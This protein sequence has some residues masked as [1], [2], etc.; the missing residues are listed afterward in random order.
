[1]KAVSCLALLAIACAVVDAQPFQ[2]GQGLLPGGN[3]RTVDFAGPY[4]LSLLSTQ[5]NEIQ[6]GMAAKGNYTDKDIIDFL[7]NV[8]CLEGQFDTYGAF[9][10]GFVGNLSGGGPAPMNARKANLSEHILPFIQEIALSEQGHALFTRHAG[11]DVPCP[12]IDYLAGFNELFAA[13]YELPAGVTVADEFG[14]AFDPWIN[15]QTFVL[16]VVT[17]EELGATGNKGLIGLITNPVIANGV[18]GLATS[19]TAFAAIERRIL[20]DLRNETVVPFNETV[21]QVFARMSAY[22]DRMDG[23]QIDDQGLTNTDPKYI[24][25]PDQYVNMIPTDVR[26]LTFSRTPQMNLNILTVGSPTGKGGFFPEGLNGAIK[27]PAGYNVSLNGTS[28]LPAQPRVATQ[29]SVAQVGTIPPPI[30]AMAPRKVEGIYSLTQVLSGLKDNGTFITRGFY[31]LPN[32]GKP[33]RNNR[34]GITAVAYPL[35]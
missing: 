27:T 3:I 16:S 13:V 18:A 15:D 8:E 23:V 28:D 25:V 12:A 1:M 9:G 33:N 6:A 34:L 35:A 20:W 4:N 21:Q 7:V 32:I 22:R 19:A 24:A 5:A 30:N 10:F 31:T 17:L 26:G 11:S 29:E 2:P 14:A